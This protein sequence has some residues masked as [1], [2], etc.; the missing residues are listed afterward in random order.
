ME[1][2]LPNIANCMIESMVLLVLFYTQ[3]TQRIPWYRYGIATVVLFGCS[4]VFTFIDSFLF[5]ILPL[6]FSLIFL[7]LL[8][9]FYPMKWKDVFWNSLIAYLLIL[10]FQVIFLCVYPTELMKTYAGFFLANGSVLLC[11]VLFAVL[12]KR[13]RFK[14][15]YEKNRL[16]I[17]LFFLALCL[18]EFVIAQFLASVLTTVSKMMV[19][20]FL[21]VQLLYVALLFIVLLTVQHKQERR[22]FAETEQHIDTLNRALDESKRSIHDF[23]KHIRYLQSTIVVH[24]QQG[25]Y[26]ELENHAN[27]Y[28]QELLERSEKE[29]T[30]LHLDD[31]VLRALLYRR[32][33]QAKFTDV[34]LCVDATTALL[35]SFPLKNYQLVELFDN[36]V[37]NA[38]ECVEALPLNRWVRIALSC[39]PL[40]NNRFR[41]TLCVQNPYDTIDFSAI[42][43]DEPYSSKK[44]SHQGVGLKK[45][46]QLVD[47]TGGTFVF[48]HD[49]HVFSV[50]IV[51]EG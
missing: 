33:L 3:V 17:R 11:S 44:G 39:E 25:Q 40:E 10:Y 24:L 7:S 45:V 13:F 1:F 15:Y 49:N 16:T 28:C 8:V 37:D 50:K 38:F 23:N 31:P 18:P 6:N 47:R 14:A 41:H 34:E 19:I 12:A 5:S 27:E 9:A 51:Y 36:L 35:P 30:F 42:I 26:T 20:C 32:R 22:Q 2:V 4:C 43:R 21:L 29:E 48:N 46:A